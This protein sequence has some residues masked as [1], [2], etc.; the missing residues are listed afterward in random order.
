MR[1]A[2][3]ILALLSGTALAVQPTRAVERP[4]P[5]CHFDAWSV[6]RAGQPLHA[7]PSADSPVIGRLTSYGRHYPQEDEYET[8]TS[9]DVIAAR[10]GWFYIANVERPLDEAGAD[11]S[12]RVSDPIEGWIEGRGIEFTIQSQKG[13]ARP[14]PRAEVVWSG[15]D[16]FAHPMRL[17]DCSGEWARIAW[18]APVGERTGWFRGLCGSQWTTCDGAGGDWLNGR[19]ASRA[20]YRPR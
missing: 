4:A 20:H 14:S 18:P 19:S 8:G 7:D 6:D 5:T 2:V 9:F 17:L 16:G 13:F 15:E 3:L 11:E 12:G 10:G 1:S